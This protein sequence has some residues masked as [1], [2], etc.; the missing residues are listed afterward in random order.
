SLE[1][2][3]T[4]LLIA[5]KSIEL[6]VREDKKLPIQVKD[7]SNILQQDG[8]SFVT[9]TLNGR[10][11]GC[12]G[13]LKAYQPLV[14]DVR[15]HAILA[16]LE[17]TRFSPVRENELKQIHIEVSRLTEPK[18]FAYQSPNDLIIYLQ[19]GKDGVVLRQ[20]YRSAT[21]LPQVWEQIPDPADFLSELCL[22]MG[23]PADAWQKQRLEVSTY[24]VQ[25]F[26][27]QSSLK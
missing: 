6:A 2:Q 17:D 10:L 26:S 14:L 5:R 4:L 21:F 9:L 8:A 7:Y 11:R 27:E 19:P 22:K 18:P 16:A 15:E 20:G 24:H 25:E 3:K 1:D 13:T 12:I 23:A